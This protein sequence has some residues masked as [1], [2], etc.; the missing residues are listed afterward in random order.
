[1]PVYF[2]KVHPE[3]NAHQDAVFCG[4]RVRN[5]LMS[6]SIC[7][8]QWLDMITHAKLS[9]NGRA[10]AL[11]RTKLRGRNLEVGGF[12]QS[13]AIYEKNFSSTLPLAQKGPVSTTV[14]IPVGRGNFRR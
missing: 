4:I 12:L 14:R 7:S 13:T 5:A 9:E 2:Q 1:M 11:A 6:S 10:S 3:A 8:R